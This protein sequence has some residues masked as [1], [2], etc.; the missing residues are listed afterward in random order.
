MVLRSIFKIGILLIFTVIVSGSCISKLDRA[1]YSPVVRDGR[2]T[3]RYF[4]PTAR[5]VQLAGD[6]PGN[7]WAEGDEGNGEVLVGLMKYDRGYWTL[8]LELTPGVYRYRF[9]VN[10]REWVLDPSNPRVVDDGMGQK[11]NLLIIP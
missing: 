3:F 1:V 10:E 4:N 2:V 5:T 9:L 11:A 7:N 6:W 8:E